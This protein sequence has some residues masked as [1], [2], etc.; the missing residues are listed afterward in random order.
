[1]TG[2]FDFSDAKDFYNSIRNSYL[3]YQKGPTRATEDLLYVVMGLNHLREWIAPDFDSNSKHWSIPRNAEQIFS[4]KIF[5]HPAHAVI[6]QLCNHTKH[7]NRT[8]NTYTE[9]GA[10]IDDWPDFD[11]VQS[12]DLGP[13]INHFVD[14]KPISEFIETLIAEYE[15]WF[16][17]QSS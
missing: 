5:S 2:V 15:T 14:G 13:P 6:R 8:M 4:K 16:V 17:S 9:H 10:P 12:T 3:R 1:M 11:A 7:S